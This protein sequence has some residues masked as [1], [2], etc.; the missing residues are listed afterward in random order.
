[1]S[2]ATNAR[3]TGQ[4]IEV[5]HHTVDS[6]LGPLLLAATPTGLVRV[7]FAL[8]DH[9]TVLVR[10][11]ETVS[12]RVVAA[13]G[14]LDEAA[15][16]FDAYFAGRGRALDVPLDMRLSRGFR[17]AVLDRLRAIPYGTTTTYTAIA[18]ELGNPRAARAV[19]TACA[20]NPLSVVVPCHR[21]VRADGVIGHYLG[22]TWAKHALL[23]LEAT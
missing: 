22:G 18:G 19:G 3:P 7:A 11:A 5:V 16:Q 9:D 8:E 17:R 1:M 14:R 21:V 12:P 23:D 13:P 15:R 6:P 10:L 4:P 20:T 2:T